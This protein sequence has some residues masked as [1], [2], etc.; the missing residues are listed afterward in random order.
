MNSK[1]KLELI[2]HCVGSLVH[3]KFVSD[4]SYLKLKD[5]I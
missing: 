4:M 1:Y 2:V 3:V 5:I